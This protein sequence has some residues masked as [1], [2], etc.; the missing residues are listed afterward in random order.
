MKNSDDS[1]VDESLKRRSPDAPL[2]CVAAS[3]VASR[4]DV[5]SEPSTQS[6]TKH[7]RPAAKVYVIDWAPGESGNVVVV[8][9]HRKSRQF[10][11]AVIGVAWL[12]HPCLEQVSIANVTALVRKYENNGGTP[13]TKER[14]EAIL[15]GIPGGKSES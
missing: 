12:E 14:A 1:N 4:R 9:H 5:P 8:G 3:I 11:K 6:G 10:V 15:Q 7:F 2:C 13:L